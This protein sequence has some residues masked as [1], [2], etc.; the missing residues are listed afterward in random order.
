MFYRKQTFHITMSR[1]TIC[2]LLLFVLFQS[3]T[4]TDYE[5][6]TGENSLMQADLVEALSDS[7][8]AITHIIRDDGSRLTLSQPYTADGI[9]PDTLYRCMLYYDQLDAQTVKLRS[10]SPIPTPHIITPNDSTYAQAQKRNDPLRITAS[11]F[12]RTGKY[13]NL[14]IDVL[15]G[16][17]DGKDVRHAISCTHDSTVT[18][19]GRQIA[20]L[21]LRHNANGAPQHYTSTNHIS[22]LTDEIQSDSI[23]VHEP[24]K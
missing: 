1:P 9:R 13:L 14:R 12:S 16:Q 4:S 7:Q 24:Q 19:S 21:T 2:I 15:T 8:S 20:H 5:T 6:G 17:V 22:L 18:I 3:C 23:I 11:W 10:L